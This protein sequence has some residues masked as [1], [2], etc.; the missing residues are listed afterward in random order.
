MTLLERLQE[1]PTLGVALPF[2]GFIRYRELN[3]VGSQ[4]MAEQV[5]IVLLHG[6][7]SGSGSWLHQL[8]DT[9]LG[10]VLA[11]DAPGYAD[12]SPLKMAEP[13]AADYAQVLWAWLDALHIK[14]VHLV[15]HSLG[16]IMAAS[17]ARLQAKRVKALTL[18]APA[19][20]YGTAPLEVQA[21]KREERMQAVAQLGMQ[22]MAEARAPRLLSKQ[23]TPEQ[24]ALAMHV[25]SR[26]NEGGYA[27]ATHM[28]SSAS[29]RSDVQ[30]FRAVSSAPIQVAC[31]DQDVITPPQACRDLAAFIAAPYT[32]LDGAGHLCALQAPQAI[33]LLISQ[34]YSHV[35]QSRG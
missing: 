4:R 3:T 11:W 16:C 1:L 17:A 20:G 32:E 34:G 21:K 22:K 2:R 8:T 15:G 33:S 14:E 29:I 7:G 6:I 35:R 13:T 26:L 19:Q 30:A 27:Q 10:H 28:L 18:L 9:Q 24:I 25:M 23:A 12:S 5:P 31:G